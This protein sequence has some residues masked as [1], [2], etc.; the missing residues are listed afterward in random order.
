MKYFRFGMA[1]ALALLGTACVTPPQPPEN[2]LA[3]LPDEQ[4]AASANNGAIYQAHHEVA[5]FENPVARHVGDI[6]TIHLVET[7]NAQKSSSTSTKKSSTAELPGPT[8]LGRPVTVHGTPILDAALDHKTTFD[9]AGDSAQSNHI[10][11]D[12]TVTV[13]KR[14]SNGSLL[15]RGQ[16]WIAINQG[17][18]Y[19]RI[20][21]IIRPIDIQP[22][23]TIPSTKVADATISYGQKGAMADANA[24]GWLQRFFNSA[25]TP[26]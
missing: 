2:Y 24:M 22:D 8:I 16:K 6:V 23:N 25:W 10:D 12:V 4:E 17:K 26:F 3:T 1:A 5:L 13:A 7:T 18:E 9:G 21:G 14:F 19:V 11:G 20:Q 15:I